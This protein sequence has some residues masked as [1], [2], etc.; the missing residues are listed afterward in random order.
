MSVRLQNLRKEFGSHI[1]VPD[2]NLTIE[3][4]EFFV[5]LGPS[6]IRL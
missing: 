3:D 1:A 6:A 2:L 5:L 4:G